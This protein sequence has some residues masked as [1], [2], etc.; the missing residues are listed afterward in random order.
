MDSVRAELVEARSS[1]DKLRTNGLQ[2][3]V[4]RINND[5]PGKAAIVAKEAA[6][7]AGFFGD[8]VAWS[9]PRLFG[10]E[11]GYAVPAFAGRVGT[12]GLNAFGVELV[13]GEVGV[14]P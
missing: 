4:G 8:A 13:E 11:G 1:L 10:F 2:S 12:P 7:V 3:H 5:W 6:S 9:T 14:H